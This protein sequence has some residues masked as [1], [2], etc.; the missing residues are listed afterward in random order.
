MSSILGQAET[1]GGAGGG[2]GGVGG[3]SGGVSGEMNGVWQYLKIV[4]NVPISTL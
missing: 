4:L 2:G 1:V 3:G